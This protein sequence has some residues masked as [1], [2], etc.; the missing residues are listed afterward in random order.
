[1]KSHAWV[2]IAATVG[3]PLLLIGA[4][5]WPLLFTDATF[6]EDWSNHLWY[7]WH[8][9]LAIRATHLPSLFLD[10]SGGVFYPY[11]AFYGGTL[12]ALGGLLSLAL[13]DA[14]LQAYILTYLLGFAAAYG[15][16]YWLA[17]M[18]GL[19]GWLAHLPGL[20]F[21]TS[22]SYLTMIY[23]LGDWPEFLAVSAMPPMIAAGLAVMRAPRV[24][25]WPA[26]ALL[27]SSCVFFGSHILTALWG[28]TLLALVGFALAL[29]VPGARHAVTPRGAARVAAL[30][31]P[32]ALVSAW[33]LLPAAAYEAQTAVAQSYPHFRG[34]LQSTM[35]IVAA[36]HLFTFSRARASGT[37]VT[38]ALPVLAIAWT[39]AST[40]RLLFARRPGRATAHR[41]PAAHRREPWMRALL[42]LTLATALLIVLMT[43]AGLIL[44]LPRFYATLQ[45]GFRLE[46][47]VLM[48]VSGM[49]LAALVLTTEGGAR[50]THWHWLL[51]PIA[52]VSIAG[53]I[54]QVDAYDPTGSRNASLVSRGAVLAS[55]ASPIYEQ[56]GLL[57]YVDDRLPIMRTPLPQVAFPPSTA[58]GAR[59]VTLAHPPRGR[60]IDTNLR[61]GPSLVDITGAKVVATDAQADDVLELPPAASPSRG[62][63]VTVVPADGLPIVAGRVVSGL[64]LIV[65][66]G[67]LAWIALRPV[68]RR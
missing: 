61:A 40:A 2:R 62:A 49:L 1:V 68:R 26:A 53:A 59:T 15:G 63:R 14:P 5:A 57:D 16:W 60:R 50:V 45:F 43:H 17:R 48:G 41:G 25:A 23:G 8:E 46:S 28:T 4:L 20:V 39:L 47:Y 6:G 55:Y 29:G 19:R 27:A 37:I 22:A 18:F 13:G 67:E 44:A 7:M 9:S 36:R 64:A 42:V 66:A 58:R 34:L 32:A 35:Y 3:G 30:V 56:E 10:Y 52:L 21:V 31:L 65:L 33:F 51:A 54:E 24:R 12:Y 38:V 11:Y